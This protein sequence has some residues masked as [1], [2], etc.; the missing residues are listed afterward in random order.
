MINQHWRCG[1]VR[2]SG[3]ESIPAHS[4]GRYREFSPTAELRPHFLCAWNHEGIDELAAPVAVFPDGCVDILWSEGKLTIAGPDTAPHI[5]DRSLANIVGIRFAPG[6]ASKWLGIPMSELVNQRVDLSELWGARAEAIAERLVEAKTIGDATAGLQAALSDIAPCIASPDR[7][8]VAA[9]DTLKRSKDI[10][11][12][13][14]LTTMLNVSERTLRRQFL[15]NFGYGPK[16]LERILRFQKFL[17]L[18]RRDPGSG[19][20]ALAF[21]ANYADQAHLSREAKSLS[22]LSPSALLQHLAA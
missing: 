18:G 22:G 21:D 6:A 1:G 17:K 2:Q 15:H 13:A 14:E 20:G 16:T 3:N 11:A 10:V 4:A 12:I 19:I 7:A 8:M 9:F 5:V